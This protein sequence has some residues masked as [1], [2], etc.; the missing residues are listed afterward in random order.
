MTFEFCSLLRREWL[1][2]DSDIHIV[3]NLYGTN[4][5]VPGSPACHKSPVDA[6]QDTRKRTPTSVP[7]QNKEA[8]GLSRIPWI[9]TRRTMANLSRHD[10]PTE[11]R[12]PQS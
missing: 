7:V 6:G 8:S 4:Y 2:I 9:G 10:C 3:T 11:P 5:T 1:Y 12:F